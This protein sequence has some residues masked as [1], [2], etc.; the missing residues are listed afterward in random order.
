L[1]H[2]PRSRRNE[3]RTDPG[4]AHARD[5]SRTDHAAATPISR[6]P[7]PTEA[8]KTV[9]KWRQLREFAVIRAKAS[10]FPDIRLLLTR[11]TP[12]AITYGANRQLTMQ[13]D[14]Y[15]LKSRI[16]APKRACSVS[17]QSLA[18]NGA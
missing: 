17:S 11:N 12:R 16:A 1:Q 8:L 9:S 18:Q 4:I 7:G 2:L 5:E 3:T 6:F 13:G 10:L 14:F 15:S